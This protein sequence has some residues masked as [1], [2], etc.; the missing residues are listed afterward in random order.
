M[1]KITLKEYRE[2]MEK[3]WKEFENVDSSELNQNVVIREIRKKH[4]FAYKPWSK[5]DIE[6]LSKFW[7]D[8]SKKQSEEKKI[9]ELSVRFGRN[10]GAIRSKLR[11]L[12]LLIQ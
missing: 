8:N 12:N 10:E 6:L 2:L 5:L 11:K 1:I 3:Y 9:H 7:N 4:P